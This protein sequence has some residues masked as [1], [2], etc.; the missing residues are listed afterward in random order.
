M[1]AAIAEKC[2]KSVCPLKHDLG[3]GSFVT[4]ITGSDCECNHTDCM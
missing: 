1:K 2:S 3:V 4:S